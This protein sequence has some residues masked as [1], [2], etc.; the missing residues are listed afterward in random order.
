MT[1]QRALLRLFSS[2]LFG[3]AGR[4]LLRTRLWTIESGEGA[5]LKLRFPQ[6][7]EY[8]SGSSEIPV[9][10]IVAQMV[11]RGDVFYDIGANVG[12]FSL[13]AARL[14]ACGGAVYAFEP[15]S[16]NAASLRSNAVL[17]RFENITVLELAAGETSGDAELLLTEWDGGSA[18]SASAVAVSDPIARRNVKVVAIDDLVDEGQCRPPG[19]VKI[20]VEGVELKVMEGMKRTIRKWK[21]IVLYEI[22]DGNRDAFSK[23]W[24]ELDD[25]MAAFGYHTTH[26][27][28]AYP[29]LKWNVGHSLAVPRT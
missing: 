21:P 19:F 16:E 27:E 22:D 6:N 20:D 10:R 14:V 29:N 13:I 23:R 15:L 25:Y 4:R 11:R 18:L 2:P 8:I 12:F 26:L 28:P 3:R 9:Q 17:N 5:G 24:K 1:Y 7:Q